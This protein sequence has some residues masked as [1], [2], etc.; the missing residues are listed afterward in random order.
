M[1]RTETSRGRK[2]REDQADRVEILREG[3]LRGVESIQTA[4][5]TLVK[6]LTYDYH[7]NQEMS[8][9]AGRNF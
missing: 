6:H 5:G 8:D 1:R 4:R 2:F 7:A 9:C 3:G